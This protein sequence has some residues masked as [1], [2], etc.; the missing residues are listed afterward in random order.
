MP[1]L[2]SNAAVLFAEQSNAP[3]QSCIATLTIGVAMAKNTR[4]SVSKK[5]AQKSY[6][7]VFIIRQMLSPFRRIRPMARRVFFL[8]WIS[9]ASSTTRF[10]Y[11]SKPR[12]RPSMRRSAC[13]CNQIW[14]RDRFCR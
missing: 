2:P 5:A 13:S 11:S 3:M 6:T 4:H 8:T 7:P 1:T 12:M 14:M 9:S 10:M